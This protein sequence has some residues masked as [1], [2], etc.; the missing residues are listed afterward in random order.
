MS[1]V[2]HGSVGLI[3]QTGYIQD[4]LRSLLEETFFSKIPVVIAPDLTVYIQ[5]TMRNDMFRM[6]GALY[7]DMIKP[8]QYNI[9][10]IPYTLIPN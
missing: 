4:P 9:S 1:G 2:I 10:N 6:Y 7:F 8:Y 5:T 3:F